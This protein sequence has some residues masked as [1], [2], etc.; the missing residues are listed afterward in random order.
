MTLCF[1]REMREPLKMELKFID[2]IVIEWSV[3][4]FFDQFNRS[5]GPHSPC[6]SLTILESELSGFGRQGY[7]HHIW[8]SN[9]E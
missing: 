5:F 6:I 2:A 9:P 1:D 3:V 4:D 7:N 8:G